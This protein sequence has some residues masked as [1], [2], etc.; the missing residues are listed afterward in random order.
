[1]RKRALSQFLCCA[2]LAVY[3]LGIHKGKVALWQGDDPEPVQVFPYSASMLPKDAREQ[4][5]AGIPIDSM[6]DLNRLIEAYLS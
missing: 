1:M 5:K 2:L 4:L 6:E 3:L